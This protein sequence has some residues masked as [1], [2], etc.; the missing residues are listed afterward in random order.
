MCTSIDEV[1]YYIFKK[2]CIQ[3]SDFLLNLILFEL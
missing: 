1:Y 3:Y 2:I